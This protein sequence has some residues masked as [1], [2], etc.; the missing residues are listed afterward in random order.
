[1][2]L[3]LGALRDALLNAGA[4]A[5]KADRAAEELA[6]YESRLA[7]IDGRLSLL[8]WMVGFDLVITAG[9]LWRLLAH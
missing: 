1:M 7:S 2:A 4:T 9:V 6:G 8:T 3:Q 5:E